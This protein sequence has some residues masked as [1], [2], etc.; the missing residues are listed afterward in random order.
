MT[1]NFLLNGI[2]DSGV[3]SGG[4]VGLHIVFKN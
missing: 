2:S 3:T 4:G 1:L